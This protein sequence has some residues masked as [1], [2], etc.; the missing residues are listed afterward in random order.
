VKKALEK[1]K[2]NTKLK[3]SIVYVQSVLKNKLTVQFISKLANGS[4]S[5]FMNGG[6]AANNENLNTNIANNINNGS[7][8]NGEPVYDDDNEDICYQCKR[9]GFL[10]LCDRYV[11]FF[12]SEALL[13]SCLLVK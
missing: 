7:S 10:I 1:F 9:G 11:C 2:W 6:A 4:T 13:V 5:T 8:A 12:G 3:E